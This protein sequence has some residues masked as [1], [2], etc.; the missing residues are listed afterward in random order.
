MT[1]GHGSPGLDL[2]EPT[3]RGT[4]TLSFD[5]LGDQLNDSVPVP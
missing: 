3:Y 2:P 5:G 4:D 1:G